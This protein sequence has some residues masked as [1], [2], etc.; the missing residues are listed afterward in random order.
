MAREAISV[1]VYL[2]YH[3]DVLDDDGE[4]MDHMGASVVEGEEPQE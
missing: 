2:P 3:V 4:S 1:P